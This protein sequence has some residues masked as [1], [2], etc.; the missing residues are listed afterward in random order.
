MDPILCSSKKPDVRLDP[1]TRKIFLN[2]RPPGRNDNQGDADRLK[3]ALSE[4][5]TNLHLP[6]PL[7]RELPRICREGEWKVTVTLLNQ[8]SH[9]RIINVEPGCSVQSHW[10]LAVDLGTTTIVIYLVDMHHGGIIDTASGYNQQVSFGGDILTLIHLTENSKNLPVFQQAAI[11]SLNSLIREVLERNQLCEENIS[12]A[13]LAGNTTMIHLLL[14]INPAQLCRSPYAPVVNDPGMLEARDLTLKINPYGAV[15]CLPGIG[16]YVGGDVIAGLLVSQLYRNKGISVLVDI[17]TNG[18]IVLGNKD[19]L[20]ACAGAAGPALEGGV[21][22]AGMRAQEGAI[23]E[24]KV[25]PGTKKITYKTIGNTSPKGICGS[26][27]IDCISEFLM[28][29]IINRKGNF[30]EDVS[31]V[32]IA[33]AEETLHGKEINITQKDIQNFIRTKGAVN[34]AMEVLMEG[35]G[36]SLN[37]LACFYAAGA[38]GNYINPESAVNLGLFPDLPRENMFFLGNSAAEG[39]RLALLD[40]DKLNEARDLA[41]RITYLEL[42]ASQSFMN[43]FNSG[44][45][46][47]HTDLDAYPTVKERLQG[48][49]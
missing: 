3:D 5:S 43:K 30:I 20:L 1:L 36:C 8:E 6:L 42:N 32:T 22:E 10:G 27:V 49:V 17:G 44:L 41:A 15:Y 23:T 35:V 26:G 46:L 7:L 47:P 4:Y 14:G 18:E 25:K 21:V 48:R 34:A 11:N 2:L 31:Y 37:E 9:S 45:F 29:G 19:F 38:F 40:K 28:K 16:S 33:S 12:A 24:V 39:S 13:S